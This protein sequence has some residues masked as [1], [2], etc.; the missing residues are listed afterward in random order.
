MR[1][2]KFLSITVLFT[3]LLWGCTART[4]SK[5]QWGATFWSPPVFG[6]HWGI[7]D[8]EAMRMAKLNRNNY[9]KKEEGN[10]STV[11]LKKTIH[12]FGADAGCSLSF[13]KPLNNALTSVTLQYSKDDIEKV[14]EELVKIYGECAFHGDGSSNG[15]Y[16]E[17]LSDVLNSVNELGQDALKSYQDSGLQL[18][19]QSIPISSVR[20]YLDVESNSTMQGK[21]IF[22]GSGAAM[23]EYGKLRK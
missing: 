6:L 15:R 20:F 14:Q 3:V 17:W 22:D 8:G 1:F 10:I 4:T 23:L 7:S 9:E 5:T 12:A 13:Y 19:S 16:S 18:P 21:L 11:Q 2:Y